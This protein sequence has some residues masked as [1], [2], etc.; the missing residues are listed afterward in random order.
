MPHL[1]AERSKS[2]PNT[3]MFPTD[4]PLS[5]VRKSFPNLPDEELEESKEVLDGYI[6]S[7]R[8]S[9]SGWSENNLKF[10]MN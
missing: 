6:A 3:P 9:M 8:E 10:S 1:G 4:D 7:V 2:K 5:G